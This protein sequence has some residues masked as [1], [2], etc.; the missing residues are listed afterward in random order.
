MENA[1][2]LLTASGALSALVSLL[3]EVALLVVALGPVQKHRP[4]ASTLLAAAAGLNLLGTI[5]YYPASIL[6]PR[7][8]AAGGYAAGY[9]M[10][11]LFTTLVRGTSGVLLILGLLRLAV[12]VSRDPT[13]YG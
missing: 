3:L 11:S 13:R 6:M 1:S 2:L 4:E 9:A 10:L 8:F 12:P 7:L 5:V